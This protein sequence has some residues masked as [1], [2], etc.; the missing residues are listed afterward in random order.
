DRRLVSARHRLRRNKSALTLPSAPRQSRKPCE[1]ANSATDMRPFRN[2]VVANHDEFWPALSDD[3]VRVAAIE[4]FCRQ[5]EGCVVRGESQ[6]AG[7]SEAPAAI[8]SRSQRRR[9]AGWP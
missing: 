7:T 5:D 2:R 6:P 8:R 9:L 4:D 1:P 3:G